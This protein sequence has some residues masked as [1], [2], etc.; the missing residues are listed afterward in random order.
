MPT[1]SPLAMTLGSTW[2]SVS[3]IRFGSPQRDPVAAASTY[4]HRGVITA[5]PNDNSLG[6]MRWTRALTGPSR[7]PSSSQRVHL[8]GVFDE[9]RFGRRS[10]DRYERCAD[11]FPFRDLHLGRRDDFVR[12]DDSGRASAHQLGGTQPR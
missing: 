4:S 11:H 1:T 7:L 3:S 10:G 12:P 8:F 5:T 6:L 2:S 9:R